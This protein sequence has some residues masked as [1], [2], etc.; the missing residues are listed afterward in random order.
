MLGKIAGNDALTGLFNRWSMKEVLS[1][2]MQ[3]ENAFCLVMCDID[4][5]KKIN[6][7]YGHN[8]GDEALKHIASI[9]FEA[10][11]AAPFPTP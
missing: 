6:D 5:F 10:V 11:P 7:T 3:G 1:Q 9:L 8:C 2:A 4:D